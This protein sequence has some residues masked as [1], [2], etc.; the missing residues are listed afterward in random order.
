MKIAILFFTY[1]RPK[2]T[3]FIINQLKSWSETAKSDVLIFHDGINPNHSRTDWEDVK[4]ILRNTDLECRT[5]FSEKNKGLRRSI[6]QGCD[7]ASNL[8]YDAFIVLEDD[9]LLSESFIPIMLSWIEKFKD[10]GRIGQLSGYSYNQW[11]VENCL[12]ESSLPSSWGW[13]TYTHVWK[14]FRSTD[15]PYNDFTIWNKLRFNY[16]GVYMF[17]KFFDHA[18]YS[19]WA[20]DFYKFIYKNQLKVISGNTSI[21]VEGFSLNST[22]GGFAQNARKKT[23][24]VKNLFFSD[25]IVRQKWPVLNLLIWR[26]KQRVL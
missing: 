10:D 3:A 2:S 1:S 20:I 8:S 18:T 23:T 21:S 24:I 13:A 6:I 7:M 5:F 17:S 26:L 15:I 14:N 25:R 9:L 19:S 22:H 16:Y 12:I 11:H 4:K